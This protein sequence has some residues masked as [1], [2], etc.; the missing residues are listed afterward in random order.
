MMKA[1]NRKKKRKAG[2]GL[3]A[4]EL[5][6]SN[7]LLAMRDESD[8]LI[9]RIVD[10]LMKDSELREKIEFHTRAIFKAIAAKL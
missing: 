3:L 8:T 7:V 6:A 2:N 10:G 5:I 4:N 9:A 1:R